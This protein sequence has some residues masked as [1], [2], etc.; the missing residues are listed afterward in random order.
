MKCV[1]DEERKVLV[2]E[3]DIKDKWKTYFHNI[4]NEGYDISPNSSRL[5]IREADQKYN[6]YRRIQKQK[7]NEALKR[8][9]NSKAVGPDNMHIEVH[10]IL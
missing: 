7:V 8:M 3:K 10:K 1:K 5:G 2:H 4:F 9:S 6:Y